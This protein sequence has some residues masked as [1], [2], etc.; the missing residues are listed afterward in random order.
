MSFEVDKRENDLKS[1]MKTLVTKFDVNKVQFY[2]T[3]IIFPIEIL[4]LTLVILV[5]S[6]FIPLLLVCI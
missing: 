6:Q 1:G 4:L 2:I 3:Y 5:I